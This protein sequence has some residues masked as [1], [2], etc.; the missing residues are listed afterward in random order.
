[1]FNLNTHVCPGCVATLESSNK[2]CPHCQYQDCEVEN[3]HI[4]TLGE[5]CADDGNV[6]RKFNDVS[7]RFFSALIEA[8]WAQWTGSGRKPDLP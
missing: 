7:P 8:G 4:G 5:L 3:G 6:K 1:M 2:G